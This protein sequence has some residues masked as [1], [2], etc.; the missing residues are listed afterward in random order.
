MSRA[1]HVRK[2]RPTEI[3]QLLRFVDEPL[4]RPPQRRAQAI[5]LQNEGMSATEIATTLQVHV[6]TIYTDLR[7]FARHGVAAVQQ[8]RTPGARPHLSAQQ[9]AA[10]CRIA[11]QSPQTFGLSYGRWSLSRLRTYLIRQRI[12]AKISRA[13]L[14]RVLNKG[15]LRCAGSSGS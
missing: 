9:R 8:S 7:A 12:V 6:N 11:D 14:W 10:I 1:L 2:P 3:R 5:L 15:G 4:E 13:H